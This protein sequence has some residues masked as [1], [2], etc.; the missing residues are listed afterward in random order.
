MGDDLHHGAKMSLKGI[1]GHDPSFSLLCI[2]GH[3]GQLV[4]FFKG[5]IAEQKSASFLFLLPERTLFSGFFQLW[6]FLG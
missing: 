5:H 4:A 1:N 3:G 2:H 6:G